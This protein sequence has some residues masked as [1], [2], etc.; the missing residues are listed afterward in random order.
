VLNIGPVRPAARGNGGLA[1]ER[2]W[3]DGTVERDHDVA[4]T[5]NAIYVSAHDPCIS[6]SGDW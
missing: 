5:L 1:Q 6:G 4:E 2:A 3:L